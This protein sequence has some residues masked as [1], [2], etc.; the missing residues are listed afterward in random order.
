MGKIDV[1]NLKMAREAL[2]AAQ[3]AL[4]HTDTN[5]APGQA[6]VLQRMVNE[7]EKLR[8]TGT[9]GKH[10]NLHTPW[11]E[12][13]DSN[14]KLCAGCERAIVKQTGY[15]DFWVHEHN[16]EVACFKYI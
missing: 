3:I 11:C 16:N 4:L 13:E 1:G 8:P 15:S 5:L 14:I 12:C 6:L 7:I 2:N 9:D 10:G